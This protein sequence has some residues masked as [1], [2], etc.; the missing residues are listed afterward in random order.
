[1]TDYQRFLSNTGRQLADSAIRRMGTVVA[2]ATDMVSFAPG[3]PDS[4]LF[5]WD[6]LKDIASELLNGRDGHTLQYGPT[7]GH[8]PL[9]EAIVRIMAERD[10]HVTT[11]EVLITSGS[12]QGIDLAARVLVSP[13]DVVLVE[14]PTF[15]GGIAAFKNAQAELAGVR[16]DADGINLD[17]LD[18][19][20][21]RARR[22]GKAVKLLYV[23]PNFQNPT[24]LLLGR[25]KRPQLLD[26][27]DRRDVL[28]VEDDPYGSLYF[29]DVATSA[30]TRPL[31]ADDREGRVL[32]L[33]TFS[34]TLAPGFRVGWMTGP[35]TLIERFE[36]AKQSTDLTSGVLDQHVVYEAVRRGVVDRL[37]PR[38]RALYRQKRDVMEEA[39]RHHLGNGL[40]W[41]AP[42]G[43]FF[44]WATLPAGHTDV[45]LLDRALKHGLVFVIGSAFFVDGSGHNTIRLSFSAP[46]P[47]RIR[48]G[49]RRLA[50]ALTATAD[51]PL[52]A[53][54]RGAS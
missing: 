45:E 19:V 11:D 16:Q 28:I 42:K 46:S 29:E 15:T 51:L 22:A 44:I 43:G 31:R 4:S 7:K 48:E 38:L 47:D 35:A 3:Y 23:I 30:E 5:P 8:A 39:L 14:L 50:A 24:G 25:K 20:W 52:E 26:W 53:V 32:Y 33:S 1:V 40:T 36:T 37:A 12:Q 13:G 2:R 54:D 9:L 6:E 18:E 41:P 34:K 17:H 27:A 10:I 21:T 49:A